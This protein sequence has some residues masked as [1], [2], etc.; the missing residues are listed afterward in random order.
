MMKKS[1][2]YL[3]ILLLFALI[4]HSCKTNS[5]TNST[6][7]HVA[8]TGSDSNTGTAD[9]PFLTISAASK[10]A[11]PG[12]IIT[13]H[14]G[15]YRE[16][17]NPPRGGNSEED[18][19]VYRAA[20]GENVTIKGSEQITTWIKDSG[21]TW[22]AELPDSFFNG[23]NPYAR[24]LGWVSENWLMTGEWTH[25][26]DVYLN[27]E[28]FYE[29][30]KIEEVRNEKNSWY[31]EVDS[32]ASVT[33]IWANFGDSDPNKE[34]TEINVRESIISP[35]DTNVNYITIKGFT[36]MHSANGWGPPSAYQG[37]AVSTN[38]GHHWIIENC[39]IINAKTCG[40]SMGNPRTRRRNRAGLDY[41]H[42]GQHII[43][44]N[45]F[46]RCGQAAIVGAGYNTGTYILG[47]YIGETSYRQEFWGHEIAAIKFHNAVDIIIENN[48]IGNSNKVRALWIDFGNQNIRLTRNFIG[49]QIFIEM[50]HGPILI[51]NNILEG[52]Y[53]NRGSGAI[54]LAHNLLNI[55]G[56]RYT[57]DPFRKSSYYKAHT[58][59][60][61]M[62][63]L[64]FVRDERW[65]NNIFIKKGLDSLRINQPA[66]ADIQVTRTTPPPPIQLGI[67]P[68]T[69]NYGCAADYNLY[70]NGSKK[71]DTFDENSI[72][73]SFKTEFSVRD[74]N[75]DVTVNFLMS[76]D[77]S[78]INCPLISSDYLGIY[79]PMKLR[80]EN[81]D[82]SPIT[83]DMDILK[84][85]R[86][87]TNP[88]VGPFADLKPGQNS[89][90]IFTISDKGP[91]GIK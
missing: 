49:V 87:Q 57:H 79:E 44:N 16:Y 14:A 46:R 85:P 86:N 66:S 90:T 26:G 73:S 4:G 37:A 51:D 19:I 52:V 48:Y 53:I 15:V 67:D 89:F 45:I 43:R 64:S 60:T 35:S 40:F 80:M 75:G 32:S 61:V 8:K 42:V 70:L 31:T 30:R 36:I 27:G 5:T 76:D 83:V 11:Q 63:E 17:V 7:Y 56:L 2:Y 82:G 1:F 84:R 22:K 13:V 81:N 18:R 6:E 23:E 29:K 39:E 24:T 58:R 20:P 62:R 74:D 9:S 91:Q 55:D 88:G 59:E 34:L 54:T 25:C 68:L 69:T 3:L 47:N 71:H 78:K 21:S 65:Y 50:N 28:A 38:G 10:V 41:N 72:V 77:A 33:H 12:D